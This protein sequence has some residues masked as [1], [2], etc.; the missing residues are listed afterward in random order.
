MLVRRQ[1]RRLEAAHREADVRTRARAGGGAAGL[2]RARRATA[3]RMVGENRWEWPV[4]DFAI[5]AIGAIDRAAVPD[6]DAGA[7]RLF[8]ND[9]GAKVFICSTASSTTKLEGAGEMPE[10]RARR[11]DGMRQLSQ[12]G[13]LRSHHAARAGARSGRGLR[14]AWSLRSSRKTWRRS[15]TPA[16]PPASRRA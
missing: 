8:I 16:A 4:T 14:R 10:P 3:S 9:S 1:G 6:A 2:G 7:G 12:H 15:S 5:L 11:R 13:K